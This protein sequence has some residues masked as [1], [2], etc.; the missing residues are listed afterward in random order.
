MTKNFDFNN[1][2]F[3]DLVY[4]EFFLGPI[5]ITYTLYTNYYMLS[6]NPRY[7]KCYKTQHINTQIK[8]RSLTRKIVPCSCTREQKHTKTLPPIWETEN[9]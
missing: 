3:Y 2:M 5:D 6:M 7:E 9:L 1:Y 4:F 8:P